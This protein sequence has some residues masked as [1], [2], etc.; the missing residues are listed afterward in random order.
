MTTPITLPGAA[1]RLGDGVVLDAA[2][3]DVTY[4]VRGTDRLAVRDVSFQI[5]QRES[6]G[7]VGESGS[8]KTTMALAITRYLAR[9]GRISSG[10]ITVNGQDL[11]SLGKDALRLLRARTVSM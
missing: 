6:F 1:D 4:A 7:L 5:G 8:G 2:H 3:V 9:N 10:S 11:A